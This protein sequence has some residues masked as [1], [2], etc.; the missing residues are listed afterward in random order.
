MYWRRFP[1][2]VVSKKSRRDTCK[3]QFSNNVSWEALVSPFRNS[4]C[5]DNKSRVKLNQTYCRN[6]NNLAGTNEYQESSLFQIMFMPL[7]SPLLKNCDAC[8]TSLKTLLFSYIY[9]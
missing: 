6:N 2:R 8:T 7:H 1:I 3:D 9:K 4:Y 5:L